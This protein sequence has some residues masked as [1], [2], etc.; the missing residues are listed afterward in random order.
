MNEF[1]IYIATAIV[2]V[3]C[4]Y[5]INALSWR[6]MPYL[7]FLAIG[8]SHIAIAL[9]ALSVAITTNER[10]SI[11]FANLLFLAGIVAVIT[12]DRRQKRPELSDDQQPQN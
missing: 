5:V 6:E 2:L 3:R 11:N 4:I 10:G 9:A 7:R 1:I 8:L 12:M